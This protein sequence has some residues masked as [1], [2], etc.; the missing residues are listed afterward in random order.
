MRVPSWQR[1]G[2]TFFT[3]CPS[4]FLTVPH[5][6]PDST[7]LS[8][9]TFL[10]SLWSENALTDA[11]H[12]AFT[13]NFTSTPSLP[14]TSPESGGHCVRHGVELNSLSITGDGILHLP[15]IPTDII[16]RASLAAQALVAQQATVTPRRNPVR[17]SSRAALMISP[18]ICRRV[19]DS[20]KL[21]M[22][23]SPET[24]A[25]RSPGWS[26]A[27]SQTAKR[28]VLTAISVKLRIFMMTTH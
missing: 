17:P 13:R 3:C 27:T 10:A 23:A 26:A 8:L 18:L 24:A 7:F 4:P 11:E 28:C 20:E 1:S 15:S 5:I 12:E 14:L 9:N 21:R 2:G 19:A 22:D 16:N 25:R 6:F